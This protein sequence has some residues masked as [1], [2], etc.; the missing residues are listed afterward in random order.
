M[1]DSKGRSVSVIVPTRNV[2]KYIGPLLHD[3]LN[4]DYSGE[5]DVLVMDSSDDRTPEIARS[6][7]QSVIRVEPEDYN[8]GGT[9][10]LGVR[11]T[12]GEICV[13]V[14]ADIKIANRQWLRSMIRHFED[15]RVAGV[16]SRQIPWPDASPMEQF[17]RLRFYPPKRRVF[18]FCKTND[19]GLEQLFFSNVSSAIRRD[20]LEQ[21]PLPEML[22]S[23]EWVWSR[24]VL[25]A[26]YRIVYEPESIVYHSH[27]Y[28][29][30]QVFREY[31]DSGASFTAV[32]PD[33]G[34]S[35]TTLIG[36]GIRY[37]LSEIQ[38]LARIHRLRKMPYALFYEFIKGLG[39]LLGTG[40]R[41]LPE[42]LRRR[43][44]KKRN[45]WDRYDDVIAVSTPSR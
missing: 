45:H 6:Y 31:F 8:Y 22:K 13:C 9:R 34:F 29:L 44:T 12:K 20:V 14:S 7:G 18:E 39:L 10:N 41:R 43:F 21:F 42:G 27:H 16:Y 35:S 40:Y 2:E 30:R 15:E 1:V 26:G 28:T 3:I 25:K 36:S 33:T 11:L 24:T 17:S 19:L 37:L 38:F 32:F 23:E 5:I 4:Q